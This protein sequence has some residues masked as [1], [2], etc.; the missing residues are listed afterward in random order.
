MQVYAH[1]HDVYVYTNQIHFARTEI[2]WIIN[3]CGPAF[4]TVF[5]GFLCPGTAPCGIVPRPYGVPGAPVASIAASQPEV[6]KTASGRLSSCE[7]G[8]PLKGGR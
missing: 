2:F 1:I 5:M 3:R 7:V 6:A 4:F 8:S